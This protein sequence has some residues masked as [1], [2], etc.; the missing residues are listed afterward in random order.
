MMKGCTRLVI[1]EW[2][3]VLFDKLP[4]CHAMAENSECG[5]LTACSSDLGSP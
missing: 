5:A 2:S 4:F 3:F 1:N